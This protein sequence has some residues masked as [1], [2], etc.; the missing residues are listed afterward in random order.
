MLGKKET[1]SNLSCLQLQEIVLPEALSI[2]S[3][4]TSPCTSVAHLEN[5]VETGTQGSQETRLLETQET[6]YGWE[7][8]EEY[9]DEQSYYEEMNYNWFR[10]I[11][12]P[13]T[14]WED[15]RK[16]RYLEVMN[17]RSDNDDICRLLER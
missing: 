8:Q 15:L 17:T 1:E 10:E 12:Q 11:S 13:R 16:L 3:D 2:K 9:E 6:S 14:Y 5:T 7:E 4:N